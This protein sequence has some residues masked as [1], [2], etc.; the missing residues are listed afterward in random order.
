MTVY[1]KFRAVVESFGVNH[2]T[3]FGSRPMCT[4]C[5]VRGAT[6]WLQS[7]P[8][9]ARA[10]CTGCANCEAQRLIGERAT[11]QLEPFV[12]VRV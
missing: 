4:V 7:D 2:P 5:G 11:F 3:G 1:R 9:A 8:V 10:I 6:H 12:D